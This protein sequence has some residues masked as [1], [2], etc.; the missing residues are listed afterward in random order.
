MRGRG[1][2][3]S[4]GHHKDYH[5][6]GEETTIV[7]RRNTRQRQLVL[8]AVCATRSHP[9][10]ED[11]YLAVHATD[12]RISRAT[13][14]RN[15]HLLAEEGEILSVRLP[16]CERFDVRTDCHAHLVC[17]R[18]GAVRDVPVPSALVRAAQE[19]ICAETGY[20]VTSSYMVYEG[21]CPSCQEAVED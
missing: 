12:E 19:R 2:D 5:S 7:K 1:I 20:N 4:F 10:A 3:E 9:T 17:P 11:V 16:G 8:D 21:V 18:C 6:C 15:L 13:V 14:Y